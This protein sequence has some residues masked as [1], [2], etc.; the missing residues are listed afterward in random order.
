MQRYQGNREI[1]N[2]GIRNKKQGAGA[3]ISRDKEDKK[4]EKNQENSKTSV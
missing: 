3:R 1:R 4:Q 2:R